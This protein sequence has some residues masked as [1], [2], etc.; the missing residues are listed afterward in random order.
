M[1]KTNGIVSGDN[2]TADGRRCSIG[3][4]RCRRRHHDE[5]AAFGAAELCERKKMEYI[6]TGAETGQQ[7]VGRKKSYTSCNGQLSVMDMDKK[8]CSNTQSEKV[9][10][11]NYT[12]AT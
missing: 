6:E 12:S 11:I 9:V 4:R 2:R 10:G 1:T 7:P 3:R 5:L 8:V